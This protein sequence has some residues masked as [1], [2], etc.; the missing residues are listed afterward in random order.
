MVGMEALNGNIREQRNDH[1]GSNQ[2]IT[3]GM[4]LSEHYSIAKHRQDGDD[5]P[6]QEVLSTGG[7]GV[8]VTAILCLIGLPADLTAS[9]LAHGTSYFQ[10]CFANK[11]IKSKHWM[12]IMLVVILS[13]DV[14][15]YSTR[16]SLLFF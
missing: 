4:C 11:V 7:D 1:Y 3:Q 15:L 2:I 13:G 8:V 6:Q 16:Y 12:N 14:E 5:H 9:I 10:I